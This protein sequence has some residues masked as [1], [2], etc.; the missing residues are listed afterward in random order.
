MDALHRVYN[1]V[2]YGA[3]MVFGA[4]DSLFASSGFGSKVL[5]A[6]VSGCT[7]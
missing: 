1:G 2:G 3:S 7:S 4:F 5:A 6:K